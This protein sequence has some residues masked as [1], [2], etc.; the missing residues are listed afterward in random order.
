MKKEPKK[1]STLWPN[2]K[3]TWKFLKEGKKYLI[4]YIIVSILEG[5]LGAIYPIISAKIILHITSGAMSQVL[6]TA[7]IVF[8]LDFLY[9]I[10]SMFKTKL[11]NKV[12][13]HVAVNIQTEIA[14]ETLKLEISEV[15]KAS[16]GVFI[17]RLNKDTADIS[18]V[19]MEYTYWLSNIISKLGIL[20]A[21][22]CLNKYMFI[23]SVVM[24]GILFFMDK[25]RSSKNRKRTS[26]EED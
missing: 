1:K 22:F 18:G 21:V 11:Y 26:R 2:V 20:Y 24:A 7:G 12:Y 8:L 10:S 6:L 5:I 16:S 23:Y 14:K 19:F 3:K 13:R 17:D 15:D 4:F 9:S 25:K